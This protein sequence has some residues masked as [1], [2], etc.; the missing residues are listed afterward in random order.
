MDALKYF[1]SVNKSGKRITGIVPIGGNAFKIMYEGGGV[2][3]GSVP[4]IENEAEKLVIDDMR[5]PVGATVSPMEA[6]MMMREHGF[7][8]PEDYGGED[9]AMPKK[10][11]Y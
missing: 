2:G 8:R 10:R 4:S 7:K 11:G 3:V 5:E 1:Q 6:E 9:F